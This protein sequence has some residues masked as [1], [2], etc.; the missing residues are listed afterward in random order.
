MQILVVE[1]ALH[2]QSSFFVFSGLQLYDR[3][4]SLNSI[5]SL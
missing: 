2:L 3:K 5:R 4:D 1:V